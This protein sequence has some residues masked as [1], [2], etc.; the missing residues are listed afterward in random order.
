MEFIKF[1]IHEICFILYFQAYFSKTIL[2]IVLHDLSNCNNNYN[3]NL[4]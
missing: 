1:V 2:L 3:N 4:V